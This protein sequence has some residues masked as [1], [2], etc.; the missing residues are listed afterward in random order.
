MTRKVL[1]AYYGATALFL[2]LDFWMGL[3]VRVAFLEPFT[4]W[5]LAYY[6]F[7][8]LCLALVVWRPEISVIVGAFESLVTLSA[9]LIS[10]GTRVILASVHGA[11]SLPEIV[12]FLI[13]GSIGYVVWTRG[14]RELQRGFSADPDT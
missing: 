10:F 2:V 13:S 1:I 5:R 7:L 3:N 8:I 9:L 6:G 4:G 12:N 11:V 14:M